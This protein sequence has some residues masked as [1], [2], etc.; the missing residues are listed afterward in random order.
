MQRTENIYDHMPSFDH[1]YRI[2]YVALLRVIK[3]KVKNHNLA[4]D[5][6]QDAFIKI[7]KSLPLFDPKKGTLY[8]WMAIIC[9]NTSIDYIRTKDFK[10]QRLTDPLDMLNPSYEPHHLQVTNIDAIDVVEQVDKLEDSYA[11]VVT[12]KYFASYTHVEIAEVLH[13]PLGTVKSRLR[14]AIRLLRKQYSQ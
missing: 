13:L 3:R 5:V 1:L 12:L 8:S 6:M 2:Y 4:K 9:L 14:I 11:I 7:W 10:N